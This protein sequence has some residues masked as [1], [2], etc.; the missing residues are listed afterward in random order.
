MSGSRV[1]N[2]ISYL[3]TGKTSNGKYD[4]INFGGAQPTGVSLHNIVEK[5]MQPFEFDCQSMTWCRP[6]LFRGG[7]DR[8]F[9]N[10]D[11]L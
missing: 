11:R 2:Y 8:Q 3:R 10:P 7:Q 4:K 5:Q 1:S 9:Q 6:V